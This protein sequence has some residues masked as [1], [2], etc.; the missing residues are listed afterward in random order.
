MIIIC[1]RYLIE[2]FLNTTKITKLGWCGTVGVSQTVEFAPPTECV[3]CC[4]CFQLNVLSEQWSKFYEQSKA[5]GKMALL[6]GCFSVCLS[7]INNI[8]TFWS[9]EPWRRGRWRVMTSIVARRGERGER[10]GTGP[11]TPLSCV[12][13]AASQPG[14]VGIWSRNL[15]S[16]MSTRTSKC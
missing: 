11:V 10:E 3:R 6:F 8:C 13:P 12:Q 4:K 5:R 1:R 15:I 9:I 2:Y 7:P 16:F 14:N